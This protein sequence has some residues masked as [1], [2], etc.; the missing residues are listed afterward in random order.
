MINAKD[1]L[2]TR[3]N[4]RILD[5]GKVKTQRKSEEEQAF[6]R[7]QELMK[8]GEYEAGLTELEKIN[9][10]MLQEKFTLFKTI[11][12][13]I[14]ELEM[15]KQEEEAREEQRRKEEESKKAAAEEERKRVEAAAAELKRQQ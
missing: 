2:Q 1:T 9:H 8:K 14:N 3:V 11:T 5:I 12:D 6:E 13:K 10:D 15:K 4:Q 7:S